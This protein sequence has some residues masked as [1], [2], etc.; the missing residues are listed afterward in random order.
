MRDPRDPATPTP[1][2]PSR[3]EVR[4]VDQALL[5]IT[6]VGAHK[7]RGVTIA[8]EKL[9]LEF[10]ERQNIPFLDQDETLTLLKLPVE[11]GDERGPV[12]RVGMDGAPPRLFPHIIFG[13]GKKKFRFLA[14]LPG[15]E[16]STSVVKVEV[17]D[18]DVS[19]I[20]R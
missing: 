3:D 16:Q 6:K 7:T 20:C 18:E 19:N 12:A 14:G 15:A 1:A 11:K 9:Q 2:T 4:G 10:V 8:V 5:A 17:R 13:V